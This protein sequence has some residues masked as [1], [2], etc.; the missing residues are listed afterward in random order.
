VT[1]L[2][3]VG[4]HHQYFSETVAVVVTVLVSV[5]VLVAVVVT[6]LVTVSVTV[7]GAYP[8][9][10]R[11]TTPAETESARGKRKRRLNFIVGW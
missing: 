5:V 11:T 3:T 4:R 7:S 2:C 6:V 10:S 1:F 8:Q 9:P